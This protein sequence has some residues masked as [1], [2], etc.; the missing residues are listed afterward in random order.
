MLQRKLH[1]KV[2]L[3]DSEWSFHVTIPSLADSDEIC[4]ILDGV[5]DRRKSDR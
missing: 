5:E 2:P 3:G 1:F 4:G